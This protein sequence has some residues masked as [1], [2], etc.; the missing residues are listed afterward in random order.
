MIKLMYAVLFISLVILNFFAI[1][2]KFIWQLVVRP[3]KISNGAW[4]R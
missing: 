4:F 1:P 2:F 3:K